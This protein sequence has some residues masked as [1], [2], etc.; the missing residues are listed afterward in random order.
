MSKLNNVQKEYFKRLVLDC[1][2]QRLTT[3]ESLTYINSRLPKGK[4]IHDS[5][6][7]HIRAQL[8][9]DQRKELERLQKDRFAY[10]NSY[11]FERVD[12]IRTYQRKLW[13][14][15]N[16]ANTKQ[17]ER[18]KAIDSLQG[19][20]TSLSNAYN[21]LP[22]ICYNS[23]KYGEL[24]QFDVIN[25]SNNNNVESSLPL[26]TA[27]TTTITV[28]DAQNPPPDNISKSSDAYGLWCETYNPNHP[29]HCECERKF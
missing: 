14:I 29:H 23:V 21:S 9:K 8:K 19:T 4:Q 22:T 5:H 18:I 25:N 26:T 11:F 28:Y 7:D 17:T 10:I 24:R 15:I 6:I 27:T 1:I 12:E 13:E 16:N 3:Q 20:T 2:V